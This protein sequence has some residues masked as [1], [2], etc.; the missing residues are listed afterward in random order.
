M[1]PSGQGSYG[2]CSWGQEVKE[3]LNFQVIHTGITLDALN[4]L[5]LETSTMYLMQS[6][7]IPTL[8]HIQI[9]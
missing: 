5:D 1:E 3:P 7:S 6:A 8:L 2:I 4:V 9:C